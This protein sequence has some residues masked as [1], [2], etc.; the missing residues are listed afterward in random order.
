MT[1]TFLPH[2][3]FYLATQ[4]SESIVFLKIL[5]AFKGYREHIVVLKGQGKLMKS[6]QRQGKHAE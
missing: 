5:E 2:P 4:V 1:P 6:L 3:V